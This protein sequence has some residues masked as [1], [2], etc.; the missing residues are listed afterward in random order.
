[1]SPFA[2]GA[3]TF[4]SLPFSH[5][6]YTATAAK[7][8]HRRVSSESSS[9]AVCWLCMRLALFLL[10]NCLLY[11]VAFLMK[12]IT[13]ITARSICKAQQSKRVRASSKL[14]WLWLCGCMPSLCTC[15]VFQTCSSSGPACRVKFSRSSSGTAGGPDTIHPNVL[16]AVD[17]SGHTD[18][19]FLLVRSRP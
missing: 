5:T 11:V 8:K 14:K 15:S 3:N 9:R 10:P 12:S 2:P 16:P 6:T 7:A 19:P 13:F 17:L 18:R 1:M 4:P